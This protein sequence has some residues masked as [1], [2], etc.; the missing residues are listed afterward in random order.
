MSKKTET[1]HATSIY[2]RQSRRRKQRRRARRIWRDMEWP[3]LGTLALLVIILGCIGFAQH[4]DAAGE[5][6]SLF[7]LLYVTLQLFVL[8]SG[9][10]TG[11]VPW[12]L[13]IARWLAP[14][15]AVYAA[16]QALLVL[17]RQQIDSLRLPRI[18]N[19]IVI[20]GLGRRGLLL[21]RRLLKQGE[22][23]VAIERDEASGAIEQCRERGAIVVLGDATDRERLRQAGILRAKYIVSVCKNDADNAEVTAHVQKL[24]RERKGRPLTC[25][26]HITDP[27]LCESIKEQELTAHGSDML[28]L[29]FFAIFQN[30]ARRVLNEH[31]I[32]GPGCAAGEAQPHLVIVGLGR[33]GES[34]LTEAAM[35]W[36]EHRTDSDERLRIDIVDEAADEKV[37]AWTLRKPLLQTA[38]A[39][40]SLTMRTSSAEF[41]RSEFRKEATSIYICLE[42][43]NRGVSVALSLAR[44]LRGTTCPVVLC[45]PEEEGIAVLLKPRPG[46]ASPLGNL[47][48]F[49]LL[50]Q[51]CD[52]RLLPEGTH[53][54]LARMLHEEYVKEQLAAGHDPADNAALV[55]W[56][57]LP[58]EFRESNRLAADHIAIMLD[59]I[60][61]GIDPSAD[62]DAGSFEF[63]EDE[64]ESLAI[65]EHERWMAERR[66]ERWRYGPV[67]DDRR[68]V[69][70]NLVPWDQL[71]HNVKEHNRNTVR[72]LPSLLARAGFSIYRAS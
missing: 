50:D 43:E 66:L 5:E 34:L 12:P 45:T 25:L 3:L 69:N 27:Q 13:Q 39:I 60:G 51:T 17:F 40:R 7:D 31:P 71:T 22:R 18:R 56:D 38:C 65:Q 37:E 59:S 55:P 6:R 68:K 41:E 1:V 28:R 44:K 52:P 62:G 24:V 47:H 54:N 2:A 9:S 53:E 10:V 63:S 19:H 32:F 61:C 21:A 33:M 35:R 64:I 49:G 20:C 4:V 58:E 23:V 46:G 42:D 14:A 67:R 26:V 36:H 70:P 30:G 57:N 72:K 8:E 29:E 48:V 15:V 11:A 16:A